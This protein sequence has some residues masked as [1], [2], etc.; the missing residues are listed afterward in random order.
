MAPGTI[1]A[2]ELS[3]PVKYHQCQ[4]EVELA[5]SRG[6]HEAETLGRAH[7][8]KLTSHRKLSSKLRG[9]RITMS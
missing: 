9:F 7:S 1:R 8:R 4:S 3:R 6:A 2:F 5:R